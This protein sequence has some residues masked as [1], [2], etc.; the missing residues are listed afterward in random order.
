MWGQM[1]Q[2]LVLTISLIDQGEYLMDATKIEQLLESSV[3]GAYI[4]EQLTHQAP[5]QEIVAVLQ[6]TTEPAS[7]HLLCYVV[8]E[9][10]L[11]SAVPL[12]IGYLADTE[13]HVR[14]SAADALGKIGDPRA[15]EALYHRFTEEETD[16][17]VRTM[18]AAALG[19]VGYQPAIPTLIEALS[20]DGPEALRGTAAWALGVLRARAALPALEEAVQREHQ[21]YSKERM[22]IAIGQIRNA[23]L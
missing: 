4:V 9:R 10:R 14:S 1:E 19:A 12:L 3:H 21:A 11:T 18:L 2:S 15:G 6:R 16:Q 5:E 8:G 23:D 22:V 20:Y 13:V 17:G 7:R